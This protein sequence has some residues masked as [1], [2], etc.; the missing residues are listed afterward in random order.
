MV[1]VSE[2]KTLERQEVTSVTASPR[3]DAGKSPPFVSRSNLIRIDAEQVMVPLT[4][5][6]PYIFIKAGSR[7]SVKF[8]H[9]APMM[10]TLVRMR[11]WNK[12]QIVNVNFPVTGAQTIQV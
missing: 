7:S 1:S 2:K 12:W 5:L 10:I 6:F 8:Y 11:V 9:C 3:P 4:Q